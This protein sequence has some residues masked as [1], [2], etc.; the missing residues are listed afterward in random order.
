MMVVARPFHRV[1]AGLLV[2]LV[3]ACTIGVDLQRPAYEQQRFIMDVQRSP[4]GAPEPGAPTLTLGPV[5][6]APEFERRAFV[7]RLD[8]RRYEGDFHFQWFTSPRDQVARAATAWFRHGGAF[9]EVLPSTRAADADYRLDLAVTALYW[10]LR[11]P[12]HHVAMVGIEAWLSRQTDAGRVE[13]HSGRVSGSRVVPSTE[14]SDR[15][16]AMEHALA[17]VLDAIEGEIVRALEAEGS[18]I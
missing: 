12:G 11:D 10:D 16:T 8:E 17:Q 6:V 18:G 5:R 14:V 4:V 1:A 2:L 3:S 9:L 15:V 7:Y 13:V